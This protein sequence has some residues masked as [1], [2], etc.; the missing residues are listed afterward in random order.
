MILSDSIDVNASAKKVFDWLLQSMRTKD[1]YKAWHPEHK[2]IR[3][4]KGEP[5]KEGSIVYIEEYLQGI[6]H[7][8]TFRFTK[9]IPNKLIKYRIL[10][11]LAIFAPGNKFII[12]PISENSC[13]FT[14]RGKIN[15]PKWLFLKV[16]KSH[17]QKLEATMLHMKGEGENLKQ[18]VENL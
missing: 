4:T 3:W 7:K 15:M 9:I 16:H 13:V 2:E 10:Y 14:A 17:K 12:E 6:L 18:A 11:P 8:L 1:S 5:L